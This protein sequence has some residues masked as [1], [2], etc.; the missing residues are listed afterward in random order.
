MMLAR[1][2]SFRLSP[3]DLPS[4]AQYINRIDDAHLLEDEIAAC[5]GDKLTVVFYTA[6]WCPGCKRLYPKFIQIASNNPSV[7]FKV[8]CV[9]DDA[10]RAWAQDAMHV[11]KLPYFQLFVEGEQVSAFSAS[12][13]SINVLRAEIAA[14][15]PCTDQLCT[16]N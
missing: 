11:S 12:L 16:T 9:G 7:H 4:N 2:P 1:Q 6:P 15:T 8:I 10:L 3:H 5:V 13:T 14:H